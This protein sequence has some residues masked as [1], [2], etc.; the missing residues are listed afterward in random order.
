MDITKPLLSGQQLQDG[1][2][3]DLLQAITGGKKLKKV[4]VEKVPTVEYEPH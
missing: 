4:E 1:G 2:R 3:G